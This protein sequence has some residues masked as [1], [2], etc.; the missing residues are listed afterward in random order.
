M[1][2]MVLEM[3]FGVPDGGDDVEYNGVGFAEIYKIF[4]MHISLERYHSTEFSPTH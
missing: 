2:I 1:L 4:A 3:E